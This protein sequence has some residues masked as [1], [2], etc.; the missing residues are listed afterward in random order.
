MGKSP[1]DQALRIFEPDPDAVYSIEITER[2]TQIPRRTIAVYVKH[3]L[4]SP[5]VEQGGGMFFDE[6][7]IRLLRRIE[8]LRTSYGVNLPGIK[9]IMQLLEE[10]EQRQVELRFRRG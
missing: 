5:M 4:V 1:K 8:Q 10:L 6:E 9:M 3:R 7:A 2:L